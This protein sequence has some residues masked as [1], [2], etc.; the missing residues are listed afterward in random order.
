MRM[1]ALVLTAALASATA[2]A[3]QSVPPPPQPVPDQPAAASADALKGPSL[4]V[5]MKFI[6]DKLNEI[7]KVNYDVALYD[8][9][10]NFNGGSR[11]SVEKN[12]VVADP[13]KCQISYHAWLEVDG[14]VQPQA[15][16]NFFL[17]DVRT[18]TVMKAEKWIQDYGAGTS[19]PGGR[20]EVTP[21]TFFL[22]VK[23]TK[24]KE[25]R[26]ALDEVMA[27][28]IAKAMIHA[29]ELCGAGSKPEPF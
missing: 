22:V 10:G 13:G 28:R 25:D 12:N 6:L 9:G 15:D 18:I 16:Y 29:V 2:L 26:F 3:Q 23:Q 19:N 17:R 7:G 24:G 5:T 14:K 11:L 20:V 27:N 21:D 4:E 8:A 1:V